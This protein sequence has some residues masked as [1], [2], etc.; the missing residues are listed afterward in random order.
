MEKVGYQISSSV[1]D[2]AE[3]VGGIRL[4]NEHTHITNALFAFVL[5]VIY[6]RYANETSKGSS[7]VMK[8]VTSRLKDERRAGREVACLSLP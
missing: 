6:I 5:S 1:N 7:V 8:H 3:S 4:L 2:G